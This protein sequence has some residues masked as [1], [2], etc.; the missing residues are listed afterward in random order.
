VNPSQLELLATIL[1]AVAVLHTFL[2]K[3]FEAIAHKFPAGSVGE[4]IFH[5]L[6]EVEVVFGFWATVFLVAIAVSLGGETALGYIEGRHVLP[7][8]TD[9]IKV[10]F[11]E[12]LFVFVIMAM[13]ATRPILVLVKGVIG[14][15]SRVLPFPPSMAFYVATLVM[16]PLLG[17]FI[18]EPAA[19]TVTALLLKERFYDRGLSSKLMYATLGL[20]FV[21]ISIGGTL[22]N[23]AAPPVVMVAGKWEFSTA[24]MLTH[25]GWKAAAAIFTATFATAILFRRELAELDDRP[26]PAPAADGPLD[27]PWWLIGL[28][29]AL[30]SGVVLLMHHPVAFFGIFLFFLGL[31]TATK[32]YQDAIKLREALLVAY[33]LMGLVVFGAL[34]K[35]W[36]Q[37]TISSMSEL[38]LYFGATGLTAITD[39]AALTFLGSQVEGLSDASKYMLVAGAVTGGGLTVIANAPNPA[40]YGILK[41]SFGASGI[42]PL[43]LLVA[44]TP[45]TILA[46]L[47]FLLLPNL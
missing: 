25:F 1:F 18:T 29:V 39:N 10:E 13:A 12:P 2:V 44:A 26:A 19:M 16:G 5:L 27:A 8:G 36:L 30:I 20:L 33:F 46:I 31:A 37:P 15:A 35:W 22:T 28:H 9:P 7:G 34:Q 4:N 24:F 38:P 32:E 23:F 45:A 43:G 41:G 14:G 42:S 47:A 21:N 40:G 6:A 17:S 11:T 3:Q